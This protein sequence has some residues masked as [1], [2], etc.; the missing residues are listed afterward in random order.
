M[1]SSRDAGRSLEGRTAIVTG[2]TGGIG[3]V[4]AEALAEAGARVVLVARTAQSVREAA[5]RLGGVAVA[6]DVS[7]E[8]GLAAVVDA[9][10]GVQQQGPDI[11]VHAAGA[12]ALAPLSET[13]VDA[14]DRMVAV[15]LRAAFLLVHAFLPGMLARGAGDIVTIGSV[16]GR[17]AFP[18]NGAYSASKFGVRGL[19]AVLAAELRGTGVRA[20]FVEP[21]AT[22]TRLWDD[23]DR[24]RNPG[25]PAREQM[26]GAVAVADAVLFAVTRPADTSVPNILVER[27]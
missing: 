13:S 14:F 17:Q 20:T 25:L 11:V 21:A 4:T 12:F 18:S 2:A 5:E 16:A 24:D 23:V 10:T 8:S 1:A 26:L 15:N 19:H 7:T 9:V 22:D 6:A 27:A 3:R